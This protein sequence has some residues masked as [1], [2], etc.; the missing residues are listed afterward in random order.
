[1]L[2]ASLWILDIIRSFGYLLKKIEQSDSSSLSSIQHRV[3]SIQNPESRIL[4]NLLPLR[5]NK[6]MVDEAALMRCCFAF[7]KPIDP[8][9]VTDDSA[10]AKNH[11]D[12]QDGTEQKHAIFGKRPQVLR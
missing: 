5:R 8:T 6:I 7:F 3:S 4:A 9:H 2:D 1:M 10:G 12:D 11:H